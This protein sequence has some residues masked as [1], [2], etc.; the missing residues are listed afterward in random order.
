MRIELI[1]K[2]HRLHEIKDLWD[3]LLSRSTV[4]DF[5]LLPRW[6]FAWWDVFEKEKKLFFVALWEE[7]KLYG[8]FPLYKM[9]KGPFRVITFTGH[10]RLADRMDFILKPGYEEECLSSFAFWIFSRS[11]WD[12][13]SLRDFGPF[14]KNAEI[15]NQI[16]RQSGK[17]CIVS[18][19][20]P[21]YF[22]PTRPYQGL[23]AYLKSKTTK[24]TRNA[25][26]KNSKRLDRLEEI[27]WKVLNRIDD[28]IV[29]EM[30]ELD[31]NRSLR[32]LNGLSFFGNPLNK[33]FIEK[34]SKELFDLD[35][36]LLST[37]RIGNELS[38]YLLLFKFDNKLLAYQT[39]FDMNH[40]KLSIGTMTLYRSIKYAFETGYEE[41][42]FLKGG[43]AYKS[44]LAEQF[45]Q[46]KR[47][48]V[49]NSGFRS[50]I[51]YLYHTRIKPLRRRLKSHPLVQKIFPAALRR[52][53]DL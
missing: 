1:D 30:A 41:F 13:L 3:D 9:K 36:V 15:F 37:F 7:K 52:K 20:E 42:D 46:N 49:Y 24:N 35:Y 19:D 28:K 17:R 33:V 50:Y 2:I 32:G 45:R 26:K 38:S 51:L 21:C 39:S 25:L 5:F 44:R 18:L 40:P 11:D 10:P 31:T 34:L 43:E 6:F 29:Q 4:R 22:I 23:E 16:S 47:L 53:W 8:L 48:L 27:E 12:L 14:S